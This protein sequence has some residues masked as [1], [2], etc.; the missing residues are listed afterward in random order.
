MNAGFIGGASVAS[1]SSINAG[2]E[3]PFPG[4]GCASRTYGEMIAPRTS[5]HQMAPVSSMMAARLTSNSVPDLRLADF[6]TTRNVDGGRRLDEINR[7]F[8]NRY[9]SVPGLTV[10]VRML[11]TLILIS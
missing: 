9:V 2:H 8:D 6:S 11:I 1:S 3:T 4:V 5:G 7:K 10:S